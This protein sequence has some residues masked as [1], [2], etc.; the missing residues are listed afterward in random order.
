MSDVD[1]E[2]NDFCRDVCTESEYR[3]LKIPI[4]SKFDDDDDD[5]R[6]FEFNAIKSGEFRCEQSVNSFELMD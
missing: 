3:Q 1:D 5:R 6:D 4:S 2:I